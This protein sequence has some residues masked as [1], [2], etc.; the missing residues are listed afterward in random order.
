MGSLIGDEKQKDCICDHAVG[1]CTRFSKCD[2]IDCKCAKRN[3]GEKHSDIALRFALKQCL[4]LIIG[5]A[6]MTTAILIGMG[7]FLFT[8]SEII[9]IREAIFGG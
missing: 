1:A 8:D 6:L 3:R 4:T 2:L 7:A 9:K 5:V